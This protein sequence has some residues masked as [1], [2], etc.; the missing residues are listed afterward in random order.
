[1]KEKGSKENNNNKFLKILNIKSQ[2]VQ[3]NLQENVRKKAIQKL[4]IN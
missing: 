2:S 3:E 1:M 4:E